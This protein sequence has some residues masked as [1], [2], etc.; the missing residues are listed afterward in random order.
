MLS[1]WTGF[2]GIP[3]DPG[4]PLASVRGVRAWCH[5]ALY[6]FSRRDR[7]PGIS[8]V[9]RWSSQI[10]ELR[11]D[12]G[13]VK[14][15]W[16]KIELRKIETLPGGGRPNTYIDVVGESPVTLWQA[17]NEWDEIQSV[18]KPKFTASIKA[19]ALKETPA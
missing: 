17:R 11:S 10:V 12:G 9:F 5:V 6:C 16:I 3:P 15:R 14:A 4:R 13:A 8:G 19:V 2:P 18:S 1:R 7:P